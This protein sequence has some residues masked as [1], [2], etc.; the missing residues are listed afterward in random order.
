MK[1][2]REE[3]KEEEREEEMKGRRT[4]GRRTK[5]EDNHKR[6]IKDYKKREKLQWEL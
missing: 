3:E 4:E 6:Q 1:E 2:W 5:E